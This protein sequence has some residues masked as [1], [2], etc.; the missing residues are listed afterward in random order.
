VCILIKVAHN[1]AAPPSLGGA[2]GSN[3]LSSATKRVFKLSPAAIGDG[4]YPSPAHWASA[5]SFAPLL[6]DFYDRTLPRL[7]RTP[8]SALQEA[9]FDEGNAQDDAQEG[10]IGEEERNVALADMS[11]VAAAARREGVPPPPVPASKTSALSSIPVGFQSPFEM[12]KAPT[13]TAAAEAPP[14]PVGTSS[15]HSST[16]APSPS[17]QPCRRLLV[18][19]L[20]GPGGADALALLLAHALPNAVPALTSQAYSTSYATAREEMPS[21][22]DLRCNGQRQSSSSANIVVHAAPLSDLPGLEGLALARA[23]IDAAVAAVQ[24]CGGVRGRFVC[25]SHLFFQYRSVVPLFVE[26]LPSLGMIT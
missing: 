4:H 5:S 20:P 26:D 24:V 21:P 3:I 10:G 9:S 25:T 13:T 15:D 11:A 7:R 8:L 22:Q 18:L 1:C 19:G 2:G 17:F 14:L 23:A 16:V 12:I 6:L